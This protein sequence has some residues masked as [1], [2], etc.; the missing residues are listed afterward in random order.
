MMKGSDLLQK[1]ARLGDFQHKTWL[2][3][4]F[5]SIRS[6]GDPRVD[7]RLGELEHQRDALSMQLHG[8]QTCAR[9][10]NRDPSALHVGKARADPCEHRSAQGRPH[11]LARPPI[12]PRRSWA[13]CSARS[14]PTRRRL[15]ALVKEIRES[16]P[17]ASEV[18]ESGRTSASRRPRRFARCKIR[19][20]ASSSSP[21]HRSRR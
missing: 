3:E 16:M 6:Q 21:G 20:Q 14:R 18:P 10:F 9:N 12:P 17:E 5:P 19:L 13:R 2:A 15:E 8:D 1:K 4:M 7:G 11:C